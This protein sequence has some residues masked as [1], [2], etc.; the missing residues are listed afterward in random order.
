MKEI[1]HY[2]I[3]ARGR[4]RTSEASAFFATKFLLVCAAARLLHY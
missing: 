1:K 3:H 4:W 2:I